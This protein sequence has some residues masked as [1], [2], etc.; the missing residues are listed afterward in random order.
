[1]NNLA[2]SLKSPSL[3]SDSSRTLGAIH[4]SLYS[5]EQAN[6]CQPQQSPMTKKFR[7]DTSCLMRKEKTLNGI[8]IVRL[9]K[10]AAMGLTTKHTIPTIIKVRNLQKHLGRATTSLAT[11]HGLLVLTRHGQMT[12]MI[13]SWKRC[14]PK[15]RE[16]NSA[17]KKGKEI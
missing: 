11:R 12:Q 10:A 15:R 13:K 2:L 9:S 3:D 5:L 14:S 1:M 16:R 17:K 6:M 7:A 8:S 4:K